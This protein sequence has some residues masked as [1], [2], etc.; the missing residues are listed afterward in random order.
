[1]QVVPNTIIG[2]LVGDSLKK[3]KYDPKGYEVFTNV[4]Q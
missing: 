3:R 1:M 4:L 2:D